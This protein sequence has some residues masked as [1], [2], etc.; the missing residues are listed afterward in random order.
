M[1]ANSTRNYKH[2]EPKTITL[3]QSTF[4]D[5]RPEEALSA[6]LALKV[7]DLV[8]KVVMPQPIKSA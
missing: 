5:K 3:E 1:P 2:L 4:I 8:K 6:M 7:E